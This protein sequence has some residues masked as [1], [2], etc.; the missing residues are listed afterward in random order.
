MDR[1]IKFGLSYDFL[2]SVIDMATRVLANREQEESE[3]NGSG[4]TS[5]FNL[6]NEALKCC[7]SKASE[8]PVRCSVARNSFPTNGHRQ[9]QVGAN[10]V[11][12][13]NHVMLI[14]EP[15]VLFE[16]KR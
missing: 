11:V 16:M 1:S 15:Q 14:G 5:L 8:N 12:K 9:V 10:V 2:N 7:P 13:E 4:I 6:S 3:F